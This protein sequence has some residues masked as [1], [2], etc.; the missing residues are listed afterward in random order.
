MQ[1][2]T[3]CPPATPYLRA[4]GGEPSLRFRQEGG[5]KHLKSEA[6]GGGG[7]GPPPPHPPEGDASRKHLKSEAWGAGRLAAQPPKP[8]LLHDLPRVIL[9]L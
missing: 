7:G 6:W 1:F 5:R 3:S 2:A 9:D 8:H 4:K